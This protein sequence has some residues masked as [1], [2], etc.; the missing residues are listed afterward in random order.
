MRV[1]LNLFDNQLVG[2]DLDWRER[3]LE[4]VLFFLSLTIELGYAEAE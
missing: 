3:R 2:F 1:F 4:V